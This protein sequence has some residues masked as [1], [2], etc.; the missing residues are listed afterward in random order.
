MVAK[1]R[2]LRTFYDICARVKEHAERERVTA[3][4]LRISRR[5]ASRHEQLRDFPSLTEPRGG[6]MFLHNSL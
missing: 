6:P 4:F 1:A 5:T 2:E 3:P